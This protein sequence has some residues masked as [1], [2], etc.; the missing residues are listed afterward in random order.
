MK[1]YKITDDCIIYNDMP[2]GWAKGKNQPKWHGSLY[3]RWREMW[4]RCKDPKHPRYNSYKDCEIDE[5][6]RYFSKYLN[7]IMKLENFDKLCND[8][9][10]WEIDKDKID[11]NNRHYTFEHLSIIYYKD[12]LDER[13]NRRGI[14]KPKKPIIGISI[15]DNSILIFK[16]LIDARQYGFHTNMI[17]H[18]CKGMYSQHKGYRWY[19]LYLEDRGENL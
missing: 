12:N 10:N 13:N 5:K 2:R 1:A 17:S 3:G 15:N 9:F 18:V 11:P 8:P 14:P 6:Y 16:S 19:Y 7:D 4:K